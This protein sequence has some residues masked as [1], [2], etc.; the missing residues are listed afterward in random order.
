MGLRMNSSLGLGLI[1]VTY[2]LAT[3]GQWWLCVGPSDSLEKGYVVP[4][5]GACAHSTHQLYVLKKGVVS[6]MSQL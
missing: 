2:V 5:S 4:Y 6:I 1:M 3:T